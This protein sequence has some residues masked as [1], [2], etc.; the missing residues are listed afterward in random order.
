[1]TKVSRDKSK[2]S[3]IRHDYGGDISLIDE[4]SSLLDKKSSK[5]KRRKAKSSNNLNNYSNFQNCNFECYFSEA[6][7]DVLGPIQ[8]PDLQQ[9]RYAIH[10]TEVST[11]YKCIYFMKLK[12]EAV[13]K[14]EEFN[15]WLTSCGFRLRELRCDNGG[16]YVNDTVTSYAKGKFLLRT[17]PPYTPEANGIS[18]RFNRLL[19]ER[20]RAMLKS[21]ELPKFLW[22]YAM[23][24]IVYIYNRIPN[25]NN[26]RQFSPYEGLF[27]K[28]PDLSHLRI[29]GCTAF[30]YNFSPTRRKLDDRAIKG[31]FVGYDEKSSAFNIY[32]P[33]KRKVMKSGH[34]VFRE[35]INPTAGHVSD[36]A[37]IDDWSLL[38]DSNCQNEEITIPITTSGE[39][40]IDNVCSESLNASATD[41]NLSL[42][43]PTANEMPNTRG[44]NKRNLSALLTSVDEIPII[45]LRED[46]V[47]NLI[48]LA[49]KL[50]KSD[51][52]LHNIVC[53]PS[54]YDEAVNS[55]QGQEWINAI[56]EE[57]TS[58]Y[59]N[60][61]WHAISNIPENARIMS[62]KWLFR[63][64]WAQGVI[65]RF[66]ARLCVR[67]FEQ[68][69]GIDYHDIFAPV[70]RLTSLRILL[71]IAAYDDLELEQIDIKTAF[72]Y[73]LLDEDI[74]IYAPEGSG[75]PP[76]T[77]LKLDKSL[78]GLKQAPRN[79]N[80]LINEFIKGLGFKRSDV[81][82]C[83][84]TQI[85]NGETVY[86]G[87][88]VDDIIFIGRDAEY[89]Q[90]IKKQFADRFAIKEFETASKILSIEISRDRK[91]RSLTINMP[92]YIDNL[93]SK[94]NMTGCKPLKNPT[95][96]PYEA[97]FN[98]DT[99]MTEEEKAHMKNVPYREAVGSLIYLSSCCRP[100]IS[101]SVSMLASVMQNPSTYH[102]HL[103]KHLLTYLASTR[104]RGIEYSSVNPAIGNRILCYSDSDHGGDKSKRKSRTGY[105]AMLNNGPISWYSKMQLN[106]A[107]SSTEAEY[108][109]LSA[110]TQEVIWLRQFMYGIHLP[111]SEATII[112]EDNSS[113]IILASNHNFSF[114]TKHIAT[115]HHFIRQHVDFCDISVLKIPTADQCADVLT[116]SLGFTVFTYL[117]SSIMTN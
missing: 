1:M 18:E 70:I 30:A 29:F 49:T 39:M 23:K 42:L 57:L 7:T 71:A 107:I 37:D 32:V 19:C 97:K 63:I 77:L 22:S 64:K 111:Q 78:Y 75:Y 83:V 55:A 80:E 20:T 41:E 13:D 81:D 46:R 98:V 90:T 85:V 26:S 105:L 69:E 82:Q 106:I 96:L 114:R 56:N 72:Q 67:G 95:P 4:C 43:P 28:N 104:L 112:F 61:V 92:Q 40:S 35:G 93:L 53:E 88:Y 94:F 47:M 16:E 58:I 113:T 115:R 74:Y 100:D 15:T 31:I 27:G 3:S 109:A 25:L 60:N 33:E 76:D 38:P 34:V 6:Y 108:Y 54:T 91:N 65:E 10:F 117:I 24:T 44:K 45:E 79:F 48:A 89:I 21:A 73:A 103:M 36:G 68:I 5:T 2:S 52:E 66:K 9:N 84:Y 116:K 12:S 11:R 51:G 14:I 87:I 59:A 99:E 110:T 50:L 102:W 8:S 86:V 101:Y 17:T 62:T